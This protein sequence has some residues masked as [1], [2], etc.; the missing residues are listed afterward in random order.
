M[1]N[2]LSLKNIIIMKQK[3]FLLALTLNDT[4]GKPFNGTW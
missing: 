2:P 1:S 3:I 4:W